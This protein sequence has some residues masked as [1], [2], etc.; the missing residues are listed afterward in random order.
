MF[1]D[2]EISTKLLITE[3]VYL[4]LEKQSIGSTVVR[5]MTTIHG[6]FLS[7]LVLKSFWLHI[8]FEYNLG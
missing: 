3:Y 4:V 6:S 8:I 7:W 2:A 1:F 5:Y